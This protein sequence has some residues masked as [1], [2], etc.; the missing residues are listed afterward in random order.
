[1]AMIVME[2]LADRPTFMGNIV[3]AN[4]EEQ[5]IEVN[6][7]VLPLKVCGYEEP[8]KPYV[9]RDY[10]GRE[11]GV[12]AAWTPDLERVVTIARFDANLKEFVF[13]RGE[14]V[15]YGEDYCR[16]NLRIKLD[17]VRAFMD[18]IRGNHHIL[19]YGDHGE[20]IVALC[21]EFGIAPLSP[22]AQ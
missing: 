16:S 4:P 11:M 20:R 18:Q 9:L 14:L 2:R 6:H 15:G 22:G 19:A 21:R 5:V 3:Y 12:T 8:T 17:N 10:H 13:V 1:M 7:C